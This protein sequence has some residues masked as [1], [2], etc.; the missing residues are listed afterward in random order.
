MY[1][2]GGFHT[3]VQ[4]QAIVLLIMSEGLKI[5]FS[6]WVCYWVSLQFTWRTPLEILLKFVILGMYCLTSPFMFSMPPFPKSN[7]DVQSKPWC[8][9]P[10]RWFHVLQTPSR[11]RWLWS[12][13]A[14]RSLWVVFTTAWASGT[15]RF[16]ESSFSMSMKQLS[17]KVTT[18]PLPSFSTIVSISQLLPV[19]PLISADL[20]SMGNGLGLVSLRY[21][22]I[23][24]I[25]L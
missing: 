12:L 23:A 20:S 24:A 13:Q 2:L 17:T 11:C 19:C 10:L 22:K 14:S 1:P 25:L 18:A 16:P 5:H 3:Q 9:I 15:D 7:M 21:G 8:P 6:F 4:S